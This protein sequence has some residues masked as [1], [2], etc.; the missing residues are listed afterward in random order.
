MGWKLPQLQFY[1]GVF[2]IKLGSLGA[3]Q[4]IAIILGYYASRKS[5][6]D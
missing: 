3:S 5:A 6:A 4:G 2:Y 1:S